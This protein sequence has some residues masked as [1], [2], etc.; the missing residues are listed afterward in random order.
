MNVPNEKWDISLSQRGL[1]SFP[2]F[3]K[4]DCNSSKLNEDLRKLPIITEDPWNSPSE[5]ESYLASI[6]INK[7][8]IEAANVKSQ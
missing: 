8:C 1:Q 5:S 7:N 2:R 3:T 6:G 4:I